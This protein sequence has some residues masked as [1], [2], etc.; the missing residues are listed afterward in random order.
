MSWSRQTQ[1]LQSLR[2][3][4]LCGSDCW[5]RADRVLASSERLTDTLLRVLQESAGPKQSSPAAVQYLSTLLVDRAHGV[6][7]FGADAA[8]L[9]PD[10][11]LSRLM[12]EISLTR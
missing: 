1:S 7:G 11:V 6:R 2:H 10:K 9:F 8:R 5:R 3:S 12:W 4:E